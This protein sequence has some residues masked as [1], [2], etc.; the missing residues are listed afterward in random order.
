MLERAEREAADVIRK[1]KK[2]AED[3]IAELRR[4]A[5]E[6]QASLK[7]HRFIAAK[8]RLD[9]AMPAFRT[10]EQPSPGQRRAERVEPGDEVMV[11]SV[12]QKG[13]VIERIGDDEFIVQLGIIKMKVHRND[14][15]LAPSE[16]AKQRTV[17]TG[18]QVKRSKDASVRTELD[19]RG[20]TLDEALI[21][22][23][24]FLDEA[25]MNNLGQVAFIHG[26]GTGVLRNGIHE[27]LR[28]HRHVKSFRLGE[29]N[30]G[31]SGITIAELK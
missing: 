7:E 29:Y 3:I 25:I 12:G 13:H 2:E 8:K 20:S 1:A 19:L 5:L 11:T 30:E 17:Q 24:R 16:S 10:A 18:A 31:G 21:E 6:E 23:D 26:K 22:A 9:E 15:R 14:L 28:K 4:M 27:W